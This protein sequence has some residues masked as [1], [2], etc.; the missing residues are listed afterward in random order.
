MRV[1]HNLLDCYTIDCRNSKILLSPRFY[2]K[3]IGKSWATKTVICLTIGRSSKFELENKK[4]P[5]LKEK[6]DSTVPQCGKTR[7]LPCHRVHATSWKFF[8]E[9]TLQ[10]FAKS[11][12][13][14]A[15]FSNLRAE[16]AWERNFSY[17]PLNTIHV[18]LPSN[19][20]SIVKIFP[21]FAL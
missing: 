8:R 14:N 3:K 16:G 13:S 21:I 2:A 19:Q 6:S 18:F 20:L 1:W 9:I 4:K 15:C 11:V 7:K 17:L 10:K 5:R 12:F